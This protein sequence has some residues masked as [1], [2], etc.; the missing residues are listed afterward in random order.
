[1]R[2]IKDLPFW[3]K[4][5]IAPAVA[6]TAML[7]MAATAFVSLANHETSVSSLDTVAFEGLRQSMVAIEA[8]TDFQTELYHLTSIAA[9]EAD[10]LKFDSTALRLTTRLDA[11]APQVKAVAARALLTTIHGK[12]HP[13]SSVVPYGS[14]KRCQIHQSS[15]PRHSRGTCPVNEDLSSPKR[16]APHRCGFRTRLGQTR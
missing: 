9:N 16:A 6:L 3:A 4:S 14:Q 11:I 5:L 2:L 10:Q 13:A 7:A 8:V 12:R 15:A 1:M